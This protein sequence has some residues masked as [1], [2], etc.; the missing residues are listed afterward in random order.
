MVVAGLGRDLLGPPQVK[1]AKSR[2]AV[3]VLTEC[4]DVEGFGAKIPRGLPK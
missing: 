3:C 2:R 1:G 4:M